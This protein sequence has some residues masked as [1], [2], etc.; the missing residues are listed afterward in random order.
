MY[1]APSPTEGDGSKS[2]EDIYQDKNSRSV[3]T[4]PTIAATAVGNR[5]DRRECGQRY[6][7]LHKRNE[8]RLD[9]DH[10]SRLSDMDKRRI[11]QGVCDGIGVSDQQRDLAVRYMDA[12]DL[13]RFG[14]QKRIEKVAL[15]VIR[16]VVETDRAEEIRRDPSKTADDFTRISENEEYKELLEKF[17]AD[18]GDIRTISDSFK[19]WI[20]DGGQPTPSDGPKA[21]FP[22]TDPNLP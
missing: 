14:N 3:E 13:D 1:E 20:G 18:L 17:D 12:L 6:E 2:A 11:T 22:G 8:G 4:H 21:G 10:S 15:A 16:Y 5:Q 7:Q 9:Q 19:E